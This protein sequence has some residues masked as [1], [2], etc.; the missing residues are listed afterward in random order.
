MFGT[1]RS[2]RI[3]TVDGSGASTAVTALNL[4]ELGSSSSMMRR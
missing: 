4:S 3:T 2:V 1:G